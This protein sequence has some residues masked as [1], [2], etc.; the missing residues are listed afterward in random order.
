MYI[1]QMFKRVQIEMKI[2][3]AI[4]FS[5]RKSER[6]KLSVQNFWQV[7]QGKKKCINQEKKTIGKK[8][9][10]EK[11]ITYIRAGTS[12]QGRD[13]FLSLFSGENRCKKSVH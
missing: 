4:D 5:E 8:L 10:W 11:D 7:L 2:Q 6:K 3:F 9:Q 1:W 12:D 13:G